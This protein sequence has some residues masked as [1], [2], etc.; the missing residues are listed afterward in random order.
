MEKIVLSRPTY[1]RLSDGANL[2]NDLADKATSPRGLTPQKP[3]A[4]QY[5]AKLTGETTTAN[6]GLTWKAKEVYLDETGLA[7]EKVDGFEWTDDNPV[8]TLNAA[9]INAVMMVSQSG[10]PAIDPD[11]AKRYWFG[12]PGG[13]GGGGGT[14]M[15]RL[16]VTND[17][18]LT[19]NGSNSSD[20]ALVNDL[21]VAITNPVQV[22]QKKF[23]TADFY[24][25]EILYAIDYSGGGYLLDPFLAGI[26]GS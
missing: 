11:P 17:F 21:N 20:V 15:Y 25:G 6:G 3:R 23:T 5:L 16:L 13:G 2:A 1:N 8:F 12:N 14:S 10:R 19:L 24:A 22:W 4:K 18:T 26:G 7:V 9:S